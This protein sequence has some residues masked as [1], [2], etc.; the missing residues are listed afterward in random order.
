MTSVLWG[1]FGI[2]VLVL[3]VFAMQVLLANRAAK[4]VFDAPYCW[5]RP[6]DDVTNLKE[7]S[8][9]GT[10]FF[11]P[12]PATQINRRLF[13]FGIDDPE[14]RSPHFAILAF[15]ADGQPRVAGWSYRQFG[16][17]TEDQAVLRQFVSPET[18]ETCRVALTGKES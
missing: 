7:L 16:F 11:L 2:A 10:G 4:S 5:L 6:G 14:V 1:L 8:F 3:L 15:G 17:Y 9:A 13:G 18:Q 12:N